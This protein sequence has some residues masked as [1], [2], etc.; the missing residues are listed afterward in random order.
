MTRVEYS[1]L[2]EALIAAATMGAASTLADF[3]WAYW[4]LPH[5]MLYGLLHGA[6][7]C[8]LLG[9]VLGLLAPRRPWMR[10]GAGA[11]LV[12]VASAASFY[13]LAPLLGWSALFA[14]W[15]ILWLLT[16]MLNRWIR[17]QTSTAA[18]GLLRGLCAALLSGA[19]FYAVSDMWLSPPP[20]GPDYPVF[21]LKWTFAFLPGF[22][23]L[24][25]RW[26]DLEA[27]TD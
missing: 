15:M 9:L 19:A 1:S 23:C 13:L 22:V 2:K 8:L 12:G 3:L 25:I 10:A 4:S 14:S 7:L 5:R 27:A 17:A 6:L 21:F 16:A 20:G 24:L 18:V 11:L 26:S